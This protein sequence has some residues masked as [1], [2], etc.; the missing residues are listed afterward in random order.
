MVGILWTF[1]DMF[2]TDEAREYNA[3]V[4]SK[5]AT[6]QTTLA[7]I[8]VFLAGISSWQLIMILVRLNIPIRWWSVGL[9]LGVLH[10][11]LSYALL[12]GLLIIRRHEKLL[13]RLAFLLSAG[14]GL[15]LWIGHPFTWAAVLAVLLGSFLGCLI[16]TQRHLGFWEDNYPPPK[17]IREA[18][19]LKHREII[20]KPHRTPV[21]KRMF[22]LLLSISGLLLSTP[23]WLLCLFSIWFDDPGPL[24]F[25]KNSVG[26]GGRTFHQYKLRTMV[27]G[28]EVSTGP[29][30]AAEEDTRALRVGRVLRK[31]ALDEL[32]QLLNILHG[33]MSFVGPRPQRTVLVHAY[34]QNMPEFAERHRVLPGLAG[35]AQVAGNYYISPRQ[36]LR[37]DRIYAQHASLG[38]DLKLIALAFALVF[39]LRWK[40]GGADRIP[41]HWLH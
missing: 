37:Y 15:L 17:E 34:L 14:W 26:K 24:F 33:D 6:W 31:T 27:R 10:I 5:N 7:W 8:I 21:A 23:V 12:E 40:P 13:Y 16:A 32:P 25:V 36:K 35:L 30:M 11:L 4:M 20:G 2:H 9:S 18:V 22:D 1:L 38:F 41:R 39:Y 29:V 3:G 19:Y 28:A